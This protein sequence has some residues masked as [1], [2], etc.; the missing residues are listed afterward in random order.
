MGKRREKRHAHS[1]DARPRVYVTSF[2]AGDPGRPL[3]YAQS[4]FEAIREL[5]SDPSVGMASPMIPGMAAEDLDCSDDIS[6]IGR[7]H[8]VLATQ[9]ALLPDGA[10]QTIFIVQEKLVVLEKA[11]QNLPGLFAEVV[12]NQGPRHGPNSVAAQFQRYRNRLAHP[13]SVTFT[14]KDLDISEIPQK[15][16]NL[17]RRLIEWDASPYRDTH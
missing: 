4:I 1:R 7:L 15:H 10:L 12:G 14:L 8:G 13:D 11:D 3:R 5:T 2:D 17:V 9:T 16:V 6:V